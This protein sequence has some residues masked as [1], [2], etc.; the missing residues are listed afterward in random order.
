MS[1]L[2]ALRA[3]VEALDRVGKALQ[4][5]VLYERA[6]TVDEFGITTFAGPVAIHAFVDDRTQQ[7]RTRDGLI[8]EVRTVLTLTS[9]LEVV[10]AT[11]GEGIAE[12]DR[13]TLPNGTVSLVTSVDGFIDASTGHPI[14]TTVMLG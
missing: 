7:V 2:D 12:K 13:F 8:R 9:I 3:G 11:S 1:L 10:M 6:L 5:T 14:A 4:S